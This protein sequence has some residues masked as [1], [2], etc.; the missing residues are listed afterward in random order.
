MPV[1]VLAACAQ[2]GRVARPLA[3]PACLR[4]LTPACPDLPYPVALLVC[5]STMSS[6]HKRIITFGSSYGLKTCVMSAFASHCR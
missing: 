2:A 4:G 5:R 3:V 6:E 1:W